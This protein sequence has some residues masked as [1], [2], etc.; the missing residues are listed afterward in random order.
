[1]TLRNKANFAMDR[2]QAP[3]N[4]MADRAKQ[5]QFDK[6][7]MN[8]RASAVRN[9]ANSQGDRMTVSVSWKKSYEE[10]IGIGTCEKQ[11]QSVWSSL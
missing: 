4:R 7:R 3:D 9:K 10:E 8:G 2:R 1:M 6:P 11:S 5:S